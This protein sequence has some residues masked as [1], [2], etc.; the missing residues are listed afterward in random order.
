LS[1]DKL[2]F[3]IKTW[4]RFWSWLCYSALN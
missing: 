3:P 2:L 1:F 4:G